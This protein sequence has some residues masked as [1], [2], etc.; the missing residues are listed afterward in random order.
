LKAK[1]ETACRPASDGLG[2]VKV[3]QGGEVAFLRVG[4]PQWSDRRQGE[5]RLLEDRI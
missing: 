4:L 5:E 3:L 2:L 1:Q